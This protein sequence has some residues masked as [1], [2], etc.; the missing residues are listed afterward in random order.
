MTRCR[1]LSAAREVFVERGYAATGIAEIVARASV[2]VGSLYHHFGG[3]VELFL[4]L[5]EDHRAGLERSAADAVASCRQAGEEHFT[6]FLAGTRAYLQA[7]WEQRDVA[8][9]FLG[10][11]G[12]PGFDLLRR[13]NTRQWLR[14]NAVL[15]GADERPADRA[16]VA[17]L[18]TTI[19]E[20][21]REVARC[22]DEAD[23]RALVTAALPL[24]S[25]LFDLTR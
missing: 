22:D 14:Q 16:L 12:P 21:G 6:L 10:G 20:L 7:C 11:D 2:S 25:R 15:L 23:A 13:Q 1:L 17:V 8:T 9:L 5:W 19:G 3:K 24:V 18:T 4:A